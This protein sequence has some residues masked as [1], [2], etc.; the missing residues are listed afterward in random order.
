LRVQG[1][2][3]RNDRKNEDDTND[4]TTSDHERA[5]VNRAGSAGREDHV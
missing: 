4:R 5:S 2:G 3:Q 1:E